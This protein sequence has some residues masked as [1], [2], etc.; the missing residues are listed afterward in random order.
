MSQSAR[1]QLHL[2]RG[3]RNGSKEE[4]EGGSADEV[5]GTLYLA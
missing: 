3:P 1:Q 2:N 5:E 4:E